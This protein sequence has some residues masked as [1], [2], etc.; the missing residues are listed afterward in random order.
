MNTIII[1][2]LIKRIL[3]DHLLLSPKALKLWLP[4][5]ERYARDTTSSI[6]SLR[7]HYC[8]CNQMEAGGLAGKQFQRWP[9][10]QVRCSCTLQDSHKVSPDPR[11]QPNAVTPTQPLL[12]IPRVSCFP[13]VA[14]PAEVTITWCEMRIT[15]WI[16]RFSHGPV[17][18]DDKC[19]FFWS[20]CNPWTRLHLSR[21]KNIAVLSHRLITEKLIETISKIHFVFLMLSLVKK[22]RLLESSILW[23][24]EKLC[25]GMAVQWGKEIGLSKVLGDA[26]SPWGSYTSSYDHFQS[27]DS[28]FVLRIKCQLWQRCH[29]DPPGSLAADLVHI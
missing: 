14:E 13:P 28:P 25:R 23:R 10:Q 21:R 7:K 26:P 12:T 11:G 19:S 22:T 9:T 17:Q 24:V 3:T 4:E 2:I 8:C 20:N 1:A 5:L 15:L 18:D 16:H 6:I 29:A 27:S